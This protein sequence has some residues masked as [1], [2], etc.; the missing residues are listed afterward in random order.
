MKRRLLLAVPLALGI[1]T[2]LGAQFGIPTIVFDPDNLANAVLRYQELQR[3]LAE[4]V[5]TYQQIRAEYQL[6]LYQ[7]QLL[8]LNTSQRYRTLSLPWPPFA[9]DDLF[10]TTQGWI[11]A[12][13]TGLQ[14]LAGYTRATQPL[15]TYGSALG[16]VAAD[17]ASRIKGRYDLVELGDAAIVHGLAALGS[18]RGRQLAVETALRNLEDDAYSKDPDFNTE[19]AVLN[20]INA[21]DIAAARLAKDA[22]SLL[23]SLLEQ[24]LLQ[25]TDRRDSIV[26]GINAH[27]AFAADARPLLARTTADTTTAL[28]TFRIP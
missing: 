28:T 9:A 26:Q 25:S 1:G 4:L 11:A 5:L 14:A 8:P 21:T 6:L 20:K 22:N 16:G 23:V 24:Q 15:L 13:N 27:I 2:T 19:V 17:E 3:Q 7:S 12:A 18:L 10:G